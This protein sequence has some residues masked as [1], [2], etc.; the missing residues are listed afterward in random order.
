ML[1][2]GRETEALRAALTLKAYCREFKRCDSGCMF[3]SPHGC[4]IAEKGSRAPSVWPL[5]ALKPKSEEIEDEETL[6]TESY[7]D[8]LEYQDFLKSGR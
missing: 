4:R 6:R 7:Y 5:D 1:T 8:L 2:P 3:Q